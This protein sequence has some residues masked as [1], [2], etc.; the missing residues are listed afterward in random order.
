LPSVFTDYWY[1]GDGFK[2]WSMGNVINRA[3]V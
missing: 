2:Y 1:A 3:A